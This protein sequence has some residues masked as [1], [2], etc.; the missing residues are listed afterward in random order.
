MAKLSKGVAGTI[1]QL[2]KILDALGLATIDV[3]YAQYR[4]EN[5]DSEVPIISRAAIRM[6]LRQAAKKGK[7]LVF[8]KSRVYHYA[9]VGHAAP[10]GMF[11]GARASPHRVGNGKRASATTVKTLLDGGQLPNSI[12]YV[13]PKF[14]KVTLVIASRVI[15]FDSLQEVRTFI[16]T[17]KEA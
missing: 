6:A 2:V 9:K 11:S 14:G 7:V 17:V 4:K 5:V 8:R 3:I 1:P 10:K 15:A 12:R 13:V 16:D